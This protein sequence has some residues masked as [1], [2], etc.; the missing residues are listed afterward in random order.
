L[1]GVPHVKLVRGVIIANNRDITAIIDLMKNFKVEYHIRT[2]M[3]TKEDQEIL[4]E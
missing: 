2:V 1:D 3:L 4:S